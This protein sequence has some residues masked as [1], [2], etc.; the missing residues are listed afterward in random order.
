MVPTNLERKM[1]VYSI[2]LG[3]FLVR[4][5]TLGCRCLYDTPYR[6]KELWKIR[7]SSLA[8]SGKK[9]FTEDS[10][11]RVR[12]SQ[13]PNMTF[14]LPCHSTKMRSHPP[15]TGFVIITFC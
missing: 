4:F 5:L 12:H 7:S 14:I 6:T 2:V 3:G 1:V 8:P 11:I 15:E 10:F 13:S 9:S